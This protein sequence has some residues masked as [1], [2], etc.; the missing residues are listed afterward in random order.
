MTKLDYKKEYKDLY[1]PKR[2]PMLINVDKITYV[3]VD[4]KGNPNTS[5]EYKEAL[6]LLYG[7]SFTIKMSKMTDNKIDGY[8]EYVVPP[9]EGLWWLD[10]KPTE[11]VIGD[12]SKFYWK[13]MIR[14]P[15]FV[16]LEVFEHAKELLK[17]KK[18][19]CFDYAALMVAMLRINHIPA[20]LIC[21]NT[22]V[23]YHAWVEVYLKG[24]GWVNPD[25]FMDEKTW[26]RMDPTFASSKFD[27]DGQY[28]AIYYY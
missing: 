12:K 6:E 23:E 16:T 5:A 15:E 22:D 24:K 21:G 14:L 8:F 7:I 25:I 13:S 3:T 17:V 20:R 19:I 18:G 11:K 27:Y 26:T 28:D 9:L 1:L 2:S 10:K 4:G